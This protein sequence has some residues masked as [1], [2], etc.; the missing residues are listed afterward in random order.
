MHCG[1][2]IFVA[3]EFVETECPVC[4]KRYLGVETPIN[5]PRNFLGAN[6]PRKQ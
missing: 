5:Y 1:A 4:G 2:M 3:S 6:P